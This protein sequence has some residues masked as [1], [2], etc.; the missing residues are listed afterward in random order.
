MAGRTQLRRVPVPPHRMTPLKTSWIDI[1]A[2]IVKHM[3]LQVR[4]NLK[5]KAVELKTSPHTTDPGALQKATDFIKAFLLGF[6]LKD[7]IAVL[8]MDDLYVDSFETDDV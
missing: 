7:A 5:R 1:T 6:E 2:P 4:M 3:K 8:R